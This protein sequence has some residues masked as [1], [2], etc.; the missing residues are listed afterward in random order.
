MTPK[1]PIDFNLIRKTMANEI[2]RVCGLTQNQVILSEPEIQDEPRP[3]KPYFSFKFTTPAAKSGDDSKDAVLDEN[4]KPTT[5][6][7]S[8]GI[9]AMTISFN[10]YGNSHEEAYQYMALWQSYLDTYPT[11]EVLRRVGVAV[12]LIGNVADLSELLNTGYEGRSQM[13]CK[14]G[15]AANVESDLGSMEEVNVQGQVTTDQGI[16]EEVNVNTIIV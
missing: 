11:Q 7:N 12:W 6:W 16:T 4:G 2:Q 3:K 5:V 8:G 10:C 15:V 9:R 14:F 1:F 13:D